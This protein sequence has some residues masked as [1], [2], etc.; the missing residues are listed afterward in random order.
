MPLGVACHVEA[1]PTPRFP[2]RTP[3]QV[4]VKQGIVITADV[5]RRVGASA[6]HGANVVMQTA[7]A[8]ATA[9]A[10]L[11]AARFTMAR[12]REA[13]DRVSDPE[14]GAF[15]EPRNDRFSSI[16]W[17]DRQL[18]A[19]TCELPVDPSPPL[20]MLL[21]KREG[22]GGRFIAEPHRPVGDEW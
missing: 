18:L 19:E 5:A 7:A 8:K 12:A 1:A 3:A 10:S 9:A 6:S 11:E 21:D 22:G 4:L 17:Y 20:R 16:S 14:Y 15:R 13:F 2:L